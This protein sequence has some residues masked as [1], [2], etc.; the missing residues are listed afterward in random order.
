[1][2][3]EMIL[4]SETCFKEILDHVQKEGNEQPIDQVEKELFRQSFSAN[5]SSFPA[6]RPLP[7]AI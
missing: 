6:V 1:M 5:F 3:E 4:N 2:L 7:E